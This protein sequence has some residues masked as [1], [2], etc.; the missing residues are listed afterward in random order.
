M[1][2]Q[3]QLLKKQAEP[4]YLPA[5]FYLLRA[6]A[7]SAQVFTALSSAGHMCMQPELDEVLPER[8]QECAALLLQLAERPEVRQ[9]LA[10]ASPSLLKGLQRFQRGETKPMHQK[11]LSAGLLRYLIRMSTR[12][13][14][15][16]LFAG[17]GLGHFAERTDLCLGETAIEGFRTRP[18]MH[19][20]LKLLRR[21]EEDKALVAQ[22]TVRLNQTAYLAG[23]RAMLPFA[24]TYGTQATRAISL[25]ATSVVRKIFELA[26]EFLPYAELQA[27]LLEAFPRA[28]IEQVERVL[29][30]LWEHGFLVSSLHPP[31]TD[32]RPTEYVRKRLDALQGIEEIKEQLDRVLERTAALDRAGIGAPVSLIATLLQEQ[33]QLVPAKNEDTLPFQVD[34]RLRVKAPLLHRAIGQIAAHAARKK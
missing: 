12:P 25:R 30:Q 11:R 4:L 22:L 23:E 5:D 15:F 28:A 6:P 8:E 10:M 20:L 2:E 32:A 14:P 27:S 9:A 13:T 26:R 18:D 33:E 29:W 3:R 17:V 21:M 19:W 16:G 7:L 1:A 24:D 34:S 31:L